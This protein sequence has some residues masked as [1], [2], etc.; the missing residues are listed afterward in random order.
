MLA[1]CQRTHLLL[2]L[3]KRQ[4][5]G[6]AGLLGSLGSSVQLEGGPCVGGWGGGSGPTLGVG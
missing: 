4:L 2:L 1:A 6:V 5:P 3:L